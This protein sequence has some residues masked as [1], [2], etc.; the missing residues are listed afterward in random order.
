MAI[1]SASVNYDLTILFDGLDDL[2]A[3]M[4]PLLGD[5]ALPIFANL[6]IEVSVQKGLC[7]SLLIS[8]GKVLSVTLI[9]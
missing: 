9:V 5:L 3:L 6:D 8:G 4:F 2:A 7:T 1:V